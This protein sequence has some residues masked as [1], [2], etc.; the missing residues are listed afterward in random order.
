MLV[1]GFAVAVSV[2]VGDVVYHDV[3]YLRGVGRR[4]VGSMGASPRPPPCLL[5]STLFPVFCPVFCGFSPLFLL[6]LLFF[7]L[8]VRIVTG[9][10]CVVLPAEGR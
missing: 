4:G 9:R 7:M 5:H 3:V 6:V 1:F 10:Q 2:A 8:V